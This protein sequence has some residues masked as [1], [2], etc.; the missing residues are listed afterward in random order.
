MEARNKALEN[1]LFVFKSRMMPEPEKE[2]TKDNN[3]PD[4]LWSY[5]EEGFRLIE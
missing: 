1:E 3:A 5:L 4:D 2:K